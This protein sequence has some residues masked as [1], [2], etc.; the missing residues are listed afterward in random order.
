MKDD[1]TGILIATLNFFCRVTCHFMPH[2]NKGKRNCF[3]G[4]DHICMLCR[5]NARC[6][7]YVYLCNLCKFPFCIFHFQQHVIANTIFKGNCINGDLHGL[8]EVTEKE[9]SK[10]IIHLRA[11]NVYAYKAN[12]NACL[13]GFCNI[14]FLGNFIISLSK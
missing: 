9:I 12:V 2:Q 6:L 4:C 7:Q 11:K 10:K 13:K 8:I 3:K 5:K 1:Q 14:L